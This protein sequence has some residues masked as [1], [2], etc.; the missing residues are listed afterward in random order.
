M[1]DVRGETPSIVLIPAVS[2]APGSQ[3]AAQRCYWFWKMS[4]T[5][6]QLPHADECGSLFV[7]ACNQGFRR[8]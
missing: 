8:C 3:E 4:T 2:I 6:N 7:F 1:E 5:L